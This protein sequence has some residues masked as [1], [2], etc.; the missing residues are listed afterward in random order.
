MTSVNPE[1]REMKNIYDYVEA[2]PTHHLPYR[3]KF[4][5]INCLNHMETEAM[6]RWLKSMKH[7]ANE[8]EL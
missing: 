6:Q 2:K 1:V 5:S 7:I 8:V 3:S 4:S